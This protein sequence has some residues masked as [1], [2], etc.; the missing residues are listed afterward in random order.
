MLTRKISTTSRFTSTGDTTNTTI[1]HMPKRKD[2]VWIR[3]HVQFPLSRNETIPNARKTLTR[4]LLKLLKK[5]FLNGREKT[6][7][8]SGVT[9]TLTTLRKLLN[10]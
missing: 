8:F 5:D 9:L 3:F 1:F 7:S 4:L 2:Q 6:N 10:E